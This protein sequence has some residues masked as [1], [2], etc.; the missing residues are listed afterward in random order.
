MAEIH[1]RLHAFF[2]C[3]MPFGK[4][5]YKCSWFILVWRSVGVAG[6]NCVFLVT[7]Y[8]SCLSAQPQLSHIHHRITSLGNYNGF[9]QPIS[10][11]LALIS[12]LFQSQQTTRRYLF[13]SW[14]LNKIEFL[15]NQSPPLT[16]PPPCSQHFH[17]SFFADPYSRPLLC[18]GSVHTAK[19]L[20]PLGPFSHAYGSFWKAQPFDKNDRIQAHVEQFFFCHFSTDKNVVHS[21]WSDSVS[22]ILSFLCF[23]WEEFHFAASFTTMCFL[24]LTELPWGRYIIKR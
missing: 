19:N 23:I 8:Q 11:E 24:T 3:I 12:M 9:Q 6:A 4:K 21:S 7:G 2:T 5:I 15:T 17:L 13:I 16:V 10:H 14:N 1:A 18:C 22:A 20:F